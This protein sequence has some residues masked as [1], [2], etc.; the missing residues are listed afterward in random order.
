MVQVHFEVNAVRFNADQS[1]LCFR[2]RRG[3]FYTA[4]DRMYR[5]LQACVKLD[6]KEMVDIE[7]FQ[8]LVQ[9][10]MLWTHAFPFNVILVRVEERARRTSPTWQ[11]LQLL[12]RITF[13]R[14]FGG[15]SG[16]KFVDR[17]QRL[18][19]RRCRVFLNTRDFFQQ[20][21]LNLA[22]LLAAAVRCEIQKY[23]HQQIRR[24][25]YHAVVGAEL[26]YRTRWYLVGQQHPCVSCTCSL[27][28]AAPSIC[29]GERRHNSLFL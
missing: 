10:K 19:Q 27:C 21:S 7:R 9:L 3:Q 16:R 15:R 24:R 13:A 2:V 12:L 4:L 20:S 11:L 5:R 14:N 26:T 22:K 6:S 28:I 23:S 1:Q 25:F 29:G 18:V 8:L 17:N